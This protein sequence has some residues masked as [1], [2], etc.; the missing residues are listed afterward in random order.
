[1]FDSETIRLIREAEPLRGL[2]PDQLPQYLSEAYA[3]V[4][5]ARLRAVREVRG[6]LDTEWLETIQ[7][8]RRLADTYE[9]LTIFLPSDDQHRAACAFVAA[10]AHHTLSQARRIEARM[11]RRLEANPSLTTFGVGPEVSACLLYLLS[12]QQA[13]AAEASKLFIIDPSR[14]HEAEFLDGLRA[15]ASG[16]GRQLHDFTM[17]EPVVPADVSG[18]DYV[19]RAAAVL[20][21][22]LTRAVRL[23]GRIALGREVT[24]QPDAVIEA[25]IRRLESTNRT[26]QVQDRRLQVR[27][28]IAGPYHVARLLRHVWAQLL[29]MS[30]AGVPAP[31]GVGRE[32]W[33]GY[34]R[35]LALRRPFLW[36]NH[37]GA[38]AAG[39]L[40]HGRSFVLT[41]P[42]GAGKTSLT[43]LRVATELLRGR[44]V[45]YLA[46]TRALVDQVSR[47]LSEKLTYL[48]DLVVRG[49]FLEDFGENAAGR[50]FVQT[51]EQCLAYLSFEPDAH[52]D[53]GLIV[54]DEAHQLSGELTSSA[55]IT[56]S[57]GL[58]SLDAMWT[59]LSLMQRAPEADVVLI[60][61]MVRNGPAVADWLS[62]VTDRPANVLDLQWK[63]TR[64]VRGAV[65]YEAADVDRLNRTLAQRRQA[66]D[67]P[68]PR[69]SDK[70]GIAAQPAGVFCHTQIWSRDSG[71]AKFPLMP[72]PV[73]LGVNDTWGITAN[74]NEVG[75]LLLGTMALAGMRPIVFSQQIGWVVKVAQAGASSLASAAVAEV[76]LTA[77]EQQLF[78]AAAIELGGEEYVEGVVDGRIG[79]HHGLL[80]WPE[81]A[82]VEAAFRRSDGLLGL[83]ATPTVAQGLNLPAEAVVF[84]GDDRWDGEGDEGRMEPLAVHELLN[85]AGRAGRAGH[86][87]HGLVIDIPSRV[88][89]VQGQDVIQ[90]MDQLMPLFG[91]P[92]Q[93]VDIVDPLT[94]VTDRIQVQGACDDVGDYLVR[95]A[96]GLS[97]DQLNRVLRASF[98][99][100]G[101]YGVEDR[102]AAQFSLLRR[103][104]AEQDGERE[105]SEQIYLE[106]WREFA[107]RF[108]VS[109]VVVASIVAT[110]PPAEEVFGWEFDDV[111][112]FVID[113]VVRNLFNLVNPAR[114]GF[115]RI[116]PRDGVRRAGAVLPTESL[117]EWE[118]RWR[119][120]MP[121]LLHAWMTAENIASIGRRIH[122]Y[123]RAGGNVNAVHLGRRFALQAVSSMGH[124]ASVVIRIIEVVRGDAIPSSLR[125]QLP[126]VAGCIREGFDDPDKLLLFWHLR[127]F[128]GR[129]PRV[130][131]HS[132]FANLGGD[133]VGWSDCIDLEDR[134]KQVRQA[135]ENRRFG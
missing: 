32:E 20:W 103:L 11:H 115:A 76:A 43:E 116:M 22:D 111:S 74:R 41:F 65:V 130:A 61:A 125:T 19:D 127:S 119:I 118:E 45:I 73:Q 84:A 105:D 13:D 85:A 133:L 1:M 128:G 71:F 109:P 37:V 123:R 92:D 3:K 50:V 89:K 93:C 108:G 62:S 17:L 81:R 121:E 77:E 97:D 49:R 87:A 14:A 51:P 29:S 56:Q 23:M 126:L 83:V 67:R 60:S 134:R 36:K 4:V 79:V 55:R 5:A 91:L 54:V 35:D 96:S 69:A 40:D 86:Y 46:P 114:A 100:F 26:L 72:E 63:P 48:G 135:W 21:A 101:V 106:A 25:V 102:V 33:E 112:A 2:D 53:V 27:S 122:C 24:Q 57:A 94:Q 70:N 44:K 104:G 7:G 12:G 30:V 117:R 58:R 16:D 132:E 6:Q 90:G 78:A 124:A 80:L 34:A 38:L 18:E 59:L 47:E 129:Y 95:R 64:Q 28:S 68:R 120:I 31:A 113:S 42:T 98:G 66:S 82:A 99:N 9:G 88:L 110:V 8:L 15:L 75:G 52:R 107:G 39:F 10:S 131:V